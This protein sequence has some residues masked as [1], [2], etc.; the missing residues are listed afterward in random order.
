MRKLSKVGNSVLLFHLLTFSLFVVSCSSDDGYQS[1]IK[2]LLMEDMS[3]TC[4]GGTQEQEYRHEDLSVYKVSHK[5]SWCSPTLD[6]NNCKLV[7]TVKANNTYDARTDTVT[8]TDT[9]AKSSRYITIKQDRNTG[10]FL[11]KSY[12]EASM[13]GDTVSTKLKYNVNYKV[14]IP[15]D[16]D[17]VTQGSASKTRGLDSTTLT[18]YVKENKTYKARDAVITVVNMTEKLTD[19]LKIHQPFNTVFKADSTNFEV[20]QYGDTITVNLT[21]NISYDVTIPDTCNWITKKSSSGVRGQGALTRGTDTKSIIFY[22]KENKTYHARNGVVT[23]S[24]SGAGASIEINIK[25]P[26]KTE[27]SLEKKYIEASQYGDTVSIKM[28]SNVSYDVTIPDDCDWITRAATRK[29]R[30]VETSNILLKVA[31]NKTYKEREAVIEVG[32]EDAGVSESITI[33]QPFNM[34]FSVDSTSFE[35][36]MDGAT[37]TVNLRHNIGYDVSIPSSCDWLS[38]VSGA[39]KAGA[40]NTTSRTLPLQS[41]RGRGGLTRAS[42][43][44]TDTTAIVFRAS[45]NTTEQER[46]ATITISNKD[47]GAETKIYVHQPFTTTFSVDSTSF[48]VGTNGGTKTVNLESNISYDVSIP[49]DCDWITLQSNSRTRGASTSSNKSGQGRSNTRGTKTIALV[50]KVSK[51]TTGKE[52]SAT[53]T[54]GNSKLGVSKAISFKQKFESTFSVDTTAVEVDELGGTFGVNVVANVS[55]S[56]QPQVS[57]LSVG[58]KTGEGDGYWTQNISVSRFTNKTD[59][60][61]GKVKFLYAAGNESKTVTVTQKRTLYIKE[62]DVTLTEAGKDSTLTLTNTEART[63][64]WSSSNTGV[65]T[66]NAGKVRAVA[67]GTAVITVRSSDGKYSDTCNITVEIPE[68]TEEETT[69]DDETSSGDGTTGDD[70]TSTGDG[71]SSGDE[72]ASTSDSGSSSDD[73]ASA[74]A[75][76]RVRYNKVRFKR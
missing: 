71:S 68:P 62:S 40:R 10:L 18:F 48:E 58:S 6:V 8:L 70:G 4:E 9:I 75:R 74:R 19:K 61:Q 66:V 36:S 21:T 12:V 46:E 52:R 56:V 59:Q 47:A 76:K 55:V 20:N 16:C 1:H 3:F 53:V 41:R 30:G 35:V 43:Q 24:N 13:Y 5:E 34:V 42:T 49:S 38:K 72:S 60:R 2:E 63:V 25:Q 65:V 27:F 54:L 39:R 7:V 69:G 33:Y 22:I 23:L 64:S 26:F 17:W 32:N 45:E 28:T 37:F 15:N 57:W 73:N 11:D 51:N 50:F 14:Q 31:E 29:T 67:D 44:G